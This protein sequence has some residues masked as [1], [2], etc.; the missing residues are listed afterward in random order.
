MGNHWEH[1]N[2]VDLR[3]TH[4]SVF[5]SKTFSWCKGENFL[6]RKL[7]Y[8]VDHIMHC[9]CGRYCPECKNDENEVVKAGEKLKES[10]KKAKMAS[11]KNNTSRDWGKVI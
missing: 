5:L 6:S 4:K 1:R 9:F 10:K 7:C 11:S 8:E 2:L 3:H